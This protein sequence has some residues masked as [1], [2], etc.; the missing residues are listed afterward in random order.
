MTPLGCL[1]VYCAVISTASLA[2]GWL[3]NVMRLT[4]KRMEL[5]LSFVAGAMLG[6]AVLHMLPHAVMIRL[7]LPVD[8]DVAHGHGLVE[9]VALWLL[10]GFLL[11]F[12]VE[13]FFAFHH[14]EAAEV[15]ES[16]IVTHSQHHHDDDQDHD[17][18]GHHADRGRDDRAVL[19]NASTQHGRGS[20]GHL[21]RAGLTWTGAAAGLT[22]H[23]VVEGIAL[24]ASIT[25]ESHGGAARLVGLGTFLV[26][27]LH[28]PFDAMTLATLMLAGGESRS[29][30]LLMNALFSMVVPIGAAAF[31]LGLAS[32]DA[33]M[34]AAALSAALAFS[35]GTFLCIALSDLLPE[36]RFHRHDRLKLSAALLA[37]LAV[38]WGTALLESRAHDHAHHDA[39][40]AAERVGESHDHG[41]ANHQH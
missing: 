30:R 18:P 19:S 11:M 26:I 24:A 29:H 38:A 14:H 22:I 32:A 10:G 8:D 27:V 23:S 37:G 7:A 28:K 34:G 3:P 17:H 1:V 25:G 9:P 5:M 39:S 40:P 41:H 6:V 36:L 12:F 16:E 13:R 31:W 35:A 21:H 15:D 20:D 4:H 2:G 33:P